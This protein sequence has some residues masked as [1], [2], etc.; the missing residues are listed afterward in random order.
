MLLCSLAGCSSS[1]SSTTA[2]ASV[3]STQPATATSAA[4]SAT[5]AS[6]AAV[7]QPRFPGPLATIERY[8][9]DIGAHS[10]GAAYGYLASGSVPQT[11]AQ[12]VSEEQ[13]AQIHS[14]SFR[15]S[16]TSASS[17]AATVSVQSLTT[18]D[19]KFGCR[20]WSGTY[21]L[22]RRTSGWV[23][24]QA[25]L[26]PTP[27]SSAQSP[28]STGTATTTAPSQVEGPG[29]T[30]HATDVQFCTTHTCI[31][32]FANGNGY[33]VQC[34]DGEWSHSGGLSGACS[35]HGGEG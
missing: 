9:R 10:Y 24:T 23:I 27:C 8:W 14:V 28:A 21:Q 26:T 31:P 13:Q 3:S 7:Q 20:T 12:F 29:S 4:P 5:S 35:Y 18:T 16:L 11:K 32:N 2:G 33:I 25:S 15:G 1:T 30:S 19:S 6:P 22:T 34:V 17:T